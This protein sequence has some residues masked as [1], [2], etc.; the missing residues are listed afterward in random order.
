VQHAEEHPEQHPMVTC[1]ATAVIALDAVLQG[2]QA[3][4]A[5]LM[6]VLAP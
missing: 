1:S 2:F 3:V 6:A 4:S 5:T